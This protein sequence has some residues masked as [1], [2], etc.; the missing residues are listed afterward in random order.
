MLKN[1]SISDIVDKNDEINFV[2]KKKKVPLSILRFYQHNNFW[3][4][5]VQIAIYMVLSVRTTI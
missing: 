5:F 4:F 1:A 2:Q 3:F